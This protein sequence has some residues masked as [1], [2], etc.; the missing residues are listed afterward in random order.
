VSG[1]YNARPRTIASSAA[2]LLISLALAGPADAYTLPTT[3]HPCDED[4]IA[5]I[6]PTGDLIVLSTGHAYNV[7]PRDRETVINWL[8]GGPGVG[9]GVL[10]CDNGELVDKA[11]P[12]GETARVRP[13]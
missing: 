2:F 6:S 9:D 7:D 13:H 12:D 8:E 3:N 11:R 1:L 4:W 5:Q 10:V